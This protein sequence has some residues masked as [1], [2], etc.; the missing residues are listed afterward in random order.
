MFR[1]QSTLIVYAI[2]TGIDASLWSSS[3]HLLGRAIEL[4]G[5]KSLDLNLG[6]ITWVGFAD[7]SAN[8]EAT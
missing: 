8:E 1:L 2:H 3:I 6:G 7:R 4:W 5:E